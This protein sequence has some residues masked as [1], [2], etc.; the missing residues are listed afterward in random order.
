M[1]AMAA[2][3]ATAVRVGAVQTLLSFDAVTIISLSPL[4]FLLS[5][6]VVA[7]T[8]AVSATTQSRALATANPAENLR[9]E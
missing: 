2:A 3:M 7:L 8:V 5:Y 9:S 1:L 6:L 4:P